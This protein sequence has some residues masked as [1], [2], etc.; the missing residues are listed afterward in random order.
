MI[1]FMNER[2]RKRRCFA[3]KELEMIMYERERQE[4]LAKTK[5]STIGSQV[6]PN[7]GLN[8]DATRARQLLGN[9]TPREFLQRIFST[10]N[11]N[12]IELVWQGCGGNLEKAIEQLASGTKS[13]TPSTVV[14]Q[15]LC[16]QALAG[17]LLASYNNPLQLLQLTANP[18]D[19]FS[20]LRQHSV[21]GWDYQQL[22]SA[23]INGA[24]LQEAHLAAL[25]VIANPLT[26]LARNEN[27]IVPPNVRQINSTDELLRRKSAFHS[28]ANNKQLVHG[29]SS[30][31]SSSSGSISPKSVSHHCEESSDSEKPKLKFSVASIIGK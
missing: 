31:P 28:L 10:H 15:Q 13:N 29:M 11:P 30:S 12:V 1:P 9:V 8:M 23:Q 3:D 21:A 7:S 16:Q 22:L 4:E 24:R 20:H 25:G 17:K 26:I 27:L 14:Q 19:V 5:S 6:I 2:M 18:A